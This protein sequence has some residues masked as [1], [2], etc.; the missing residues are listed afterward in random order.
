MVTSIFK[1]LTIVKSGP[2]FDQAAKLGKTSRSAYNPGLWLVLYALLKNWVVA[3]NVNDF[4]V[5][6]FPQN[7]PVGK[8]E[9]VIRT[10]GII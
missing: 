10:S 9:A 5:I 6:L 4:A 1:P 2:I 3:S 7:R 8:I